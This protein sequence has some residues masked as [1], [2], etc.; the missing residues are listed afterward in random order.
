[1]RGNSSA[2]HPAQM[3]RRC[4]T[5]GHLGSLLRPEQTAKRAASCGQPSSCSRIIQF[6]KELR[7]FSRLPDPAAAHPLISNAAH[8]SHLDRLFPVGNIWD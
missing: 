4:G 2:Y 1:M 8:V 7:D 3:T 5:L 6:F